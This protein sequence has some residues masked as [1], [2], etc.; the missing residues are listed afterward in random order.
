MI[1]TLDELIH[2]TVA[3]CE[4]SPYLTEYVLMQRPGCSAEEIQELRQTLDL[5]PGYLN[6][7]QQID[8]DHVRLLYFHFSP[9]PLTGNTLVEK[10]ININVLNPHRF[11][12]TIRLYLAYEFG[13]FDG[14]RLAVVYRD[15]PF[16]KEQILLFA[17]YDPVIPP[18]QVL[19]NRFDQFLFLVGSL[20]QCSEQ[21]HRTNDPQKAMA[22]FDRALQELYP[23]ATS[24]SVNAWKSIANMILS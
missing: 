16:Q 8:L 24:E 7:I 18:P 22:E 1:R 19:A 11:I 14:D 17:T 5:P 13:S 15:G 2:F 12:P 20:N 9:G 3:S 6:V 4:E 21:V 23:E 10:L